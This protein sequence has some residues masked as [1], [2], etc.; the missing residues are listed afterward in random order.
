MK[1]KINIKLLRQ[2]KRRILKYPHKYDQKE[3]C[4]TPCCIAGWICIVS[5][6]KRIHTCEIVKSAY[7]KIYKDQYNDWTNLFSDSCEWPLPYSL[8]YKEAKTDKARA[9]IAARRIEAFIKSN[10]DI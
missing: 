7:E 2:V 1:P 3:A 4:G 6:I 8:Q 5:K 10:G 9:G